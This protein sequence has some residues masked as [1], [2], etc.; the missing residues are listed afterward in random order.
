MDL[1]I[2]SERKR[3]DDIAS[4]S[5]YAKGANAATVAY[6]FRVFRRHFRGRRCLEMGPAEG[7]MTRHLYEHFSQLTLVEGAE[8]FV[9]ELRDRYP[10]A[11][12]HCSL[13]EDFSTREKFDTIVLGHVLEHVDEPTTILARAKQWLAEKGVIVAAV[14]NARSVH[15]QAAVIMGLLK[16]E[17]EMND[18]DRHHGHR[19]VYDPESL[20]SDFQKSG[21]HVDIF[22]GY[23]L[24]P[25]SNAQIEASWTPQMLEGFMILGER[26]PDIAG[27]IYVVASQST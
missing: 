17:H 7:L 18:M 11:N 14:P 19:R 4:D 6:S 3:L 12:V 10:K 24:K 22:G 25:L 27:E 15:R 8:G 1:G 21:L 26:Y 5:W 2:T 16:E 23:W 20:R 13:F 9:R